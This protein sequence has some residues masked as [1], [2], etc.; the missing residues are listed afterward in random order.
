MLDITIIGSGPAGM[1]AAIYVAR[2]GL[3]TMVIEQIHHGIG[4]LSE[5]SHIENY[6]GIPEISGYELGQRFRDHAAKLGV[7]FHE[8]KVIAIEKSNDYWILHLKNGN[9]MQSKSVIFAT[10]ASH[11]HLNIPG[12]KELTGRGVSY[13]AICDGAFYKNKDVAVI[14]GGNT[15]LEDALSLSNLCHRVYLIHRRDTFR[16]NTKSLKKIQQKSNIKITTPAQPVEIVGDR[17]FGV[18]ALKL[19]TNK[20]LA[21]SGIFIA[22]GMQPATT[23]LKNII[24]LDKT[25]YI[26]ADE[27][28]ETSAPGLFAA[29]DVRT[30]QN[31][32]IVTAIADGANA[33][34]SAEKY[35]LKTKH[36]LS[37]D[38]S[39][40]GD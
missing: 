5:S 7:T 13:C 38:R 8:G 26:I 2:T 34:I 35:I 24:A 9:P 28:G 3:S 37:S 20:T 21:V 33:A 17:N 23:I 30:K 15:A 10:G 27:N 40:S 19:S 39:D 36:Q 4:Q 31:R 22:V 25:G 29:G 6:P 1:S 18:T 12:E 14:G 11:R 16:G 32:Q